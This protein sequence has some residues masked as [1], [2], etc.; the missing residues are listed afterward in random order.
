MWEMF[1]KSKGQY[2]IKIYLERLVYRILTILVDILEGTN[3][4]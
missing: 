2:K 1:L 3:T 4:P